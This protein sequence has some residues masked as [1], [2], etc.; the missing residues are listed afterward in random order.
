M[1]VLAWFSIILL[2]IG[3]WAQVWKTYKHKEVRDLSLSGYVM[4]AIGFFILTIQAYNEGSTIFIVKQ[5]MTFIP[6]AIIVYLIKAHDKDKWVPSIK[7][8][9]CG[10][11]IEKNWKFCS[12]CGRKYG[13]TE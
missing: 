12:G 1:D 2:S 11:I 10:N 6:V 8:C 7:P 4:L 9:K 13:T 3:Y 5:I